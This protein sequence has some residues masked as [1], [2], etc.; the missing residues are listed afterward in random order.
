MPGKFGL[1]KDLIQIFLG[2]PGFREDEGFLLKRRY[3]FAFLGLLGGGES[4]SERGQQN[5]ALR[6][7]DDGLCERV[8]LAQHRHLLFEFAQ[9]AGRK[10]LRGG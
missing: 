7:L 3:P 8:K 1:L 6:V 10:L 5:F 2:S 4:A 9:L